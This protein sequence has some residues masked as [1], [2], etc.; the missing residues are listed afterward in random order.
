MDTETARRR[1]LA[2]RRARIALLVLV[3]GWFFLPYD[4][5][6]RIPIWVPFLAA[7]AVEVQFF[8][9][10]WLD[11]RRGI[12]RRHRVDRRPQPHD[13]A[14]LGGERWLEPE[15]VDEPEDEEEPELDEELEPEE[16]EPPRRRRILEPLIVLA[17]V[18]GIVFL[19]SRPSGWDAVSAEDRERAERLFSR[20][21]SRIAGRDV[22]V[23]CDTSGEYVGF[24]QDADGAAIVGG[25]QAY[26][27]PSIC[28]TLYQ[29]AFKDRV[30]SFPRTGRAIAVLAHEAWHLRGVRGEGV[31]NCYAF[32]S[33]VETG[34][35]LGLPES[36]ARAMMREQL[37]TNAVDSAGD[38]QY[39]VSK[40]CRDGGAHDLRPEDDRFP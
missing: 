37:A 26:V 4:V 12:V 34:A 36:E 17:L 25:D 30:Q 39:L 10:G 32:Q 6:T 1:A 3:V 2:F 20:E 33:G 22:R 31:A 18:G 14:E 40:E 13:V 29:L 19:A 16:P 9:G 7:L 11:A 5:R 23:D 15:S 8:V 28:D 27:T 24:V 35:N 38:P 21:A